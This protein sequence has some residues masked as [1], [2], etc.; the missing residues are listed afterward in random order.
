M[1]KERTWQLTKRAYFIHAEVPAPLYDALLRI[2][3]SEV[4]LNLSEYMRTLIEKDIEE[5]GIELA[6]LEDF[7]GEGREDVIVSPVTFKTGVISTRVP[8]IM[9]EM[10]NGLL[11]SGL[12]LRV[13]DYLRYVV[14]KDLE[15]RDIEPKPIKAGV[16]EEKKPAKTW[17]PSETTKV[18]TQIPMQMMDDIDR[19]LTSG[20]YLRV[21]DY[22]ID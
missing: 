14:K 2:L 13:S 5:K 22:I 4:H 20:L 3:E 8:I 19:L 21:S 12:Y 7:G 15:S 9:M 6:P 18:S 17:R 16:E 1:E 10:I 11:E